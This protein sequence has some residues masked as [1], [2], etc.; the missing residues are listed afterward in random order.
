[1]DL[2]LVDLM[3][4]G[5]DGLGLLQKLKGSHPELPVIM[6]TASSGVKHA[7]EAM[8]V[9]A[10][11]YLN[12]PFDVDDLLQRI[13]S[14][15]LVDE[16]PIPA[17]THHIERPEL[18][19]GQGNFGAMVGTHPL[20]QA[21]YAQITQIA[22]NEVT[23][24]ITGE[25]GTGKELVAH[26]IH[27][28]S[29]RGTGPF[30]ALNCAAIP[31]SMIDSELF[32]HEKGAFPLA[33]EQRIG[34]LELANGGTLFLDE[35]SELSPVVQAK[36][37][38]FIQQQELCRVG[39]SKPIKCSIRVLAATN[40]DLLEAVKDGRFR[41][42]LFYRINVVHLDLPRL[43]DRREDISPLFSFFVER[44]S[45]IY[46]RTIALAP[47]ALE[48]LE[49]YSWPGNVR[50]LENVTES[51][52]A[53]TS[54][55]EILPEH[56]PLRIRQEAGG[57]LKSDVLSGQ[58]GFEAAEKAFETELILK[59]LQRTGWVQTRAAEVLGISR[60]ILKYK[61][62]KLGI[63]DEGPSEQ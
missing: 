24:L 21:L 42:D 9:G 15:L 52:L 22:V 57:D 31:E 49:R 58:I 47:R 25:S 54:A 4:P 11:D 37:L 34:Q 62:D 17:I 2:V 48:I 60:R 8:K 53:L 50:E 6:L 23:V 43:K 16:G 46:S 59:A 45:T 51:L 27:K 55:P 5:I 32:G 35:I 20:M 3:M 33:S 39:S 28:R 63:A 13:E 61:M 14:T 10:V 26:E 38:R 29:A 30:V 41:S 19:E 36:L 56:L 44:F 18:P 7:V 12:K 40:C 1:V